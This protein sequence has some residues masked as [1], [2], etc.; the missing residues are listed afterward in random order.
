LPE[1]LARLDLSHFFAIVVTAAEAGAR[2]PD[3]AIFQFALRTVGVDAA[4]ALH[5]GNEDADR[6]GA[7]AAGLAFEPAPLVTLPARLGL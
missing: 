6:I 3:P 1:Q 7:H 5:V 4:R 2:K